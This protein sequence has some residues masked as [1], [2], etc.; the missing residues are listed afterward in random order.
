MTRCTNCNRTLVR[1]NQTVRG[2][3]QLE[4]LSS[5]ITVSLV[6]TL[7]HNIPIAT[8]RKHTS[9]EINVYKSPYIHFPEGLATA[10]FEFISAQQ[11]IARLPPFRAPRRRCRS[12]RSEAIDRPRGGS[13][14]PGIRT[15][16]MLHFST[17]DSGV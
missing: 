16:Y 4:L 12:V 15:Y 8:P 2:L 1:A 9:S 11:L 13:A 14:P 10:C 17:R 3:R 5:L 6:P 7:P